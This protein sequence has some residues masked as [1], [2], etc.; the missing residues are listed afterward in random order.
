MGKHEMNVK[1]NQWRESWVTTNLCIFCCCQEINV[2]KHLFVQFELRD[3]KIIS[4]H[5]VNGD[6]G[7]KANLIIF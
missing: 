7:I 4:K 1:K 2:L 5:N 6:N 3:K